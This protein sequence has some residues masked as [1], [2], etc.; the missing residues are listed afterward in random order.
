MPTAFV[1]SGDGSPG[2]VQVGMLQ[3]P[4]DHDMAPD[5]LIGRSA[6]ALAGARP[7]RCAPDGLRRL[8]A[9]P[10]A[11][12]RLRRPAPDRDRAAV[13]HPPSVGGRP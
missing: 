13:T 7:S 12:R 3:A 11:R 5:L 1:L 2:A 6:G 9:T 10:I 8:I 4:A